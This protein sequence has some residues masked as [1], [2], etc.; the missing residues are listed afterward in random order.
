MNEMLEN[1]KTSTFNQYQATFDTFRQCIE[2]GGT[3]NWN[4]IIGSY[5]LGRC[6]FHALFFG[7][8]YLNQGE[9]AFRGQAFHAEHAEIFEGYAEL[10]FGKEPGPAPNRDETILYLNYLCELAEKV[11]GA[12]TEETLSKRAPYPWTE[13]SMAEMHLYNLRHLQHHA[14]Q[15]GLRLRA[16][17]GIDVPWVKSRV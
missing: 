8:L 12:E 16:E 9:D 1:F 3:N 15:I 13:F 4:L 6:V 14:A 2:L 7:D 10:E 11:I 17:C 5:E